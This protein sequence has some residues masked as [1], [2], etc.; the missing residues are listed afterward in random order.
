MNV[1]SI[2]R[3]AA[4]ALLSAIASAAFAT[5]YYWGSDA[6]DG[7]FEDTS[8]WRL[9][10]PSGS[11]ANA[12]P[13]AVTDTAI[14][15]NGVTGTV[16]VGSFTAAAL[17]NIHFLGGSDIALNLPSGV[18][19]S[20]GSTYTSNIGNGIGSPW[21]F[22]SGVGRLVIAGG[23]LDMRCSPI[24]RNNAGTPQLIVR[25]ATLRNSSWQPAEKDTASSVVFGA[26][27]GATVENFTLT[28]PNYI[29]SESGHALPR[30]WFAG[31][32]TTVSNL[33]LAATGNAVISPCDVCFTNGVK[34]VDSALMVN[35]G[36]TML[37]NGASTFV[38]NTTVQL[39][40]SAATLAVTNATMADCT[41]L[42]A[43]VAS[44]ETSTN[45]CFSTTG[46][47]FDGCAFELAAWTA[48]ANMTFG[49]GTVMRNLSSFALSGHECDCVIEGTGTAIDAGDIVLT[50]WAGHAVWK[51]TISTSSV[52]TVKG[53]ASLE[54]AGFRAG[55]AIAGIGHFRNVVRVS[56]EGSTLTV[57]PFASG[58]N[59]GVAP[60]WFEQI[61]GSNGSCVS[62][63]VEISDG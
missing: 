49:Q 15:G 61:T 19:S 36:G 2:A 54:C 12:S 13:L 53:G 38:T 8:K 25:S 43:G 63:R 57:R 47:L 16:A 23:T 26:E 50:P 21:S 56:G 44:N 6:G 20:P 46:S 3:P 41:I 51:N 58:F 11:A 39:K 34:V 60:V 5:N 14:F 33:S 48:N 31:E 28:L 30:V 32:G 37:I 52:F 35:G 40:C 45:N 27:S 59:N 1:M 9:L 42:F 7:D 4:T 18:V 17:P 62:N 24:I 29:S 10:K 55:S 22:G